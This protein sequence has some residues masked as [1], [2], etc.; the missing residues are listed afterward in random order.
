MPPDEDVQGASEFASKAA[1]PNGEFTYKVLSGT[2][3]TVA[4]SLFDLTLEIT[5]GNTCKVHQV[6]V[7]QQAWATPQY[8]LYSSKVTKAQC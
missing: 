5:V 1:F 6:V 8:T 3:Q 2:E 4:G 7:G